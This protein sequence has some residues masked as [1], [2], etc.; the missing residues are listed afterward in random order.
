MQ[1]E[2]DLEYYDIIQYL[3]KIGV[4]DVIAEEDIFTVDGTK[5]LNGMFAV[6][7][8]AISQKAWTRLLALL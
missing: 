2:S 7:K 8:R 4:V 3:L 6:P 1:V 5:V